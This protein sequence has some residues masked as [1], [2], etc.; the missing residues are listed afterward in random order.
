MMG[1]LGLRGHTGS[2]RR[3]DLDKGDLCS[4]R[5]PHVLQVRCLR[6]STDPATCSPSPALPLL[7]RGPGAA[8]GLWERVGLVSG[9]LGHP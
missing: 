6:A 8:S 2:S 3:A 7:S 5:C 9:A 4:P 1:V